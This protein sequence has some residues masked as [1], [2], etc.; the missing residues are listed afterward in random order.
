MEKVSNK[1]IHVALLFG[2]KSAEHEVSIRSAQS[3]Y[4]VLDKSKYKITLVG[5][6]KHGTWLSLNV[7]QF[8]S[9]KVI[10]SD[11]QIPPYSIDNLFK[12][13]KSKVDVVFPVLHGPFG[14]D[15]TIQGLLKLASVL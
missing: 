6:D 12:S 10:T 5:I 13:G 2:G 1:K 4:N 3:I 11:K 15:G 14:E 9:S 7:Q 8:L